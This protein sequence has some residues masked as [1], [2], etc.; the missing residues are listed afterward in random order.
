MKGSI[1]YRKYEVKEG[2][3]GE[4]DGSEETKKGSSGGGGGG[5]IVVMSK[6][7]IEKERKRKMKAEI[8][9][10]HV[11]LIQDAFWEERPYILG[12]KKAAAVVEE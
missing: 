7:Q 3:G 5:D 6:K 10:E 4:A 2:A 1:V 8:V 11:D 9:V 12:G